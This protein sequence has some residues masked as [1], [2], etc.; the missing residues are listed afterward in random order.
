MSDG[1]VAEPV[2]G[3]ALVVDRFPDPVERLESKSGAAKM[4]GHDHGVVAG[5]RRRLPHLAHQRQHG[6]AEPAI[7]PVHLPRIGEVKR[8]RLVPLDHFGAQKTTQPFD[9]AVEVLGAVV[10]ARGQRRAG[11]ST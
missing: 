11:D 3:S 7:G 6:V 4:L 8:S 10:G 1:V 5:S 9:E 2:M